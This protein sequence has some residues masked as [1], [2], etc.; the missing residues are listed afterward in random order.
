MKSEVA[1]LRA[2]NRRHEKLVIKLSK[3]LA[4]ARA[5]IKRLR[6][7]QAKIGRN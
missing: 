5:E 3:Q 2:L 1:V 7:R 6:T 4:A